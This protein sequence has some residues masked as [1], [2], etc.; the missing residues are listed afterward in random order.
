MTLKEREQYDLPRTPGVYFFKRGKEILYIGKATNLDQRTKSYFKGKLME[1]RGPLIVK[2][3]ED[4]DTLECIETESA[5]EAL[6][7]ESH[8]IKKHQPYYNSR[9]KDDKSYNY[10]VI[11]DEDFPRVFTVRKR[12]LDIFR[13]KKEPLLHVFGPFPQGQLLREALNI[14]RKIFPFYGKKGRGSY[15]Q[16]FYQQMGLE[17]GSNKQSSL[18]ENYLENIHYIALFFEGKKRSIIKTLKK[19]MMQYAKNLEFEKADIL[20]KQM[21]SLEH[22]RDVALMRRDFELGT[23]TTLFRIEAYDIAHHQGQAMVGVM[24][25]HNGREIDSSEHRLFNIKTVSSS[26]D[27]AALSEVLQRRLKNTQWVYPSM[28]VVDGGVAQKRAME[29]VLREAKLSIPVVSVVKDERHKAKAL[30]GQKKLTEKYSQEILAINAES[31]RF[32]IS[33]HKRKHRKDFLS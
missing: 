21:F 10:V 4:T 27:T 28:I 13:G 25:V 18:R 26:N 20:K 7:L 5:L 23:E 14:I 17:P 2:M 9:E 31:H 24:V 32:A 15:A 11:T 16:E 33:A 8:L 1:T 22:I 19:R 29:K 12:Q 3:V 6:L 30:L